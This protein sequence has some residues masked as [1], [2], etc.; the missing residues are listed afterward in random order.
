VNVTGGIEEYNGGDGG[1]D[2]GNGGKDGNGGN[3]GWGGNDRG[4]GG[5][6]G[7]GGKEDVMR[8][9]ADVGGMGMA[10]RGFL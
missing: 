1:N 10:H 8:G 9:G 4:K 6:D 3:D 5:K 7:K 2:R